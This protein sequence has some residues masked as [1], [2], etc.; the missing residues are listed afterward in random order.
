[1]P[2]SQNTQ[3]LNLCVLN[4]RGL[5]SLN[6]R[7]TLSNYFTV[8]Q[9]DVVCI[10]ETWFDSNSVND[11]VFLDSPFTVNAR[12][13]RQAGSHGGVLIATRDLVANTCSILP[14][15]ASGYDFICGIIVYSRL[16][17]LLIVNV[18][19]PPISSNYYIFSINLKQALEL[20]YE[21]FEAAVSSLGILHKDFVITGDFNLPRSNWNTFTSTC[22]R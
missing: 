9:A 12:T 13:D 3:S 21:Q 4:C 15:D 6:K 5:I 14:I 16:N 17:A 18:Y 20:C 22:F 8:H 7:I 1:M 10:T 2:T 11:H 19:L